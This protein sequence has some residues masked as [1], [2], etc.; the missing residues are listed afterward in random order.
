MSPSLSRRV[1]F[2]LGVGVVLLL[3]CGSGCQRK[4]TPAA[5]E[6]IDEATGLAAI[7]PT[8]LT[9]DDASPEDPSASQTDENDPMESPKPTHPFPRRTKAPEFP[10]GFEWLNTAGPMRLHDLR[11]KFVLLD[12]WTYCCINCMHILPE[13]KKLERK[14]PNELVV[15]GVHS[16]KFTT[17]KDKEN[18]ASAILR[19]EIEH[20]V[21]VDENHKI[22]D[23]YQVR[24]WPSLRVIDPQG[25]LIAGHSGEITFEALDAFFQRAIPYYKKKKLLDTTPLQFALLA[26][27]AP[28]TSLRF[29]GKVLAD[30]EGG[31]L[32]ITDSN[33]NRIVVT[34]LQ[35]KVQ[36]VIGSGKQ[37][38]ADGDFERASFHHPQGCALRGDVLYVADTENHMIRKVD[39]KKQQV[40]TIAGTG[41]QASFPWPRPKGLAS[42]RIP[43]R[44]VGV[45]LRTELNSPWALWVH[46]RYLYIAMAGTHQIWRMT[47]DEKEIEPYAGN[48]REDIVDGRLLPSEPYEVAPF[49]KV[50]F[51]SFAQPSGLTSDGTSLFV[52]DSEGSSI[53]AVPLDGKG[54]VET[55][56]GTAD[57]AHAR[58]FTFGDVDGK[59]N[60]VRLQ[61]PLGVTWHDGKIYVADTY[62]NKV[63]VIDAET[64]ETRTL[65]GDGQAGHTDDPPRF[66]EPA[67]ISFAAGKLF[68]ADTN[69]H[70]IRVVDPKTGKTTT[71]TI[72]PLEPPSPDMDGL[73]VDL[74]TA[75]VNKNLGRR[76]LK[77]VDGAIQIRIAVDLPRG[78]KVNP[79][80]NVD[81]WITESSG[82][83]LFPKETP[84]LGQ[85]PADRTAWTLKLPVKEGS[86]GEFGIGVRFL[87]CQTDGEGVCRVGSVAWRLDLRLDASAK[88]NEL[89]LEHKVA[90][91]KVFQMDAL[92]R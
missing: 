50:A 59:R 86:G 83:S 68:V 19:Y 1:V 56:V 70:L 18:I 45:P 71:L 29:P 10:R 17:E 77:P 65:A 44:W 58:L 24:A 47:L 39:L 79:L 28:K 57:L 42:G 22:W 4:D 31:R 16:A 21:V 12:F 63:K 87:Y 92:D 41:K 64:G 2:G 78:W 34:D 48:S 88:G 43:K 62:N 60:E 32:F 80:G 27:R 76:S 13:L 11:G 75:D 54:L 52:A 6:S 23:S 26:H 73:I 30:G 89:T 67:G 33:H 81:Y 36:T 72:S 85:L 5:L 35:G 90:V 9:D 20:P 74:E 84:R 61:H 51:S 38:S 8:S 40:E 55:V 91:P 49:G 37:G 53:R 7:T 3:C 69:N 14:Y 66:D 25:N 46:D 82:K 15:I